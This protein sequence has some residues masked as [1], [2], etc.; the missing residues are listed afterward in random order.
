MGVRWA[1]RKNR[2]ARRI[3]VGSGE[4]P[5]TCRA[6]IER[7][8]CAGREAGGRAKEAKERS[9]H[10]ISLSFRV[11]QVLYDHNE[12]YIYPAKGTVPRRWCTLKKIVGPTLV[13]NGSS[14]PRIWNGY[15]REEKEAAPKQGVSVL[16]ILL[17]IFCART[18]IPVVPSV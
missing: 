11:Y 15:N 9:G 3:T 18:S 10:K 6:G 4:C 2:D 8:A 16:G 12:K 7:S 17:I 5:P 14:C 13:A 1:P